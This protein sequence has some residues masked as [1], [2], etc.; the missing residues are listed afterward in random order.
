MILGNAV[1]CVEYV[2][3]LAEKGP[4]RNKWMTYKFGK[5]EIFM[6]KEAENWRL[7]ELLLDKCNRRIGNEDWE[8]LKMSLE[9]VD[10]NELSKE[11][12]EAVENLKKKL[13][14]RRL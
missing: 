9:E 6:A 7:L 14:K 13:A 1:R 3:S 10:L 12:K 2:L 8:G 5:R 4:S 11:E